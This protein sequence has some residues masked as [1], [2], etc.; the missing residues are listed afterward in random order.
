MARNTR[1]TP[2]SEMGTIEEN[3]EKCYQAACDKL[4]YMLYEKTLRDL[5]NLKKQWNDTCK[6]AGL[7]AIGKGY[8]AKLLSIVY[9]LGGEREI[10]THNE[11]LKADIGYIQD[12]YGFQGCSTPNQEVAELLKSYVKELEAGN[13]IPQWATKLMQENYGITL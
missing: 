11:K 9:V 4:P 13:S 12:V 3:I 10:F 8:A 1:L 5:T 6:A 2:P 7:T